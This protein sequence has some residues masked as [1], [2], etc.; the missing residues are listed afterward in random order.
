M[1]SGNIIQV[2]KYKDVTLT[3]TSP[4][5]INPSVAARLY[6]SNDATMYNSKLIGVQLID[7]D[8]GSDTAVLAAIGITKDPTMS[9]ICIPIYNTGTSYK[10]VSSV[11][12]RIYYI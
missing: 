3:Y 10:D 2:V 1:A 8:I 5:T 6:I 9:R 7:S 4:V 12:L 11:T